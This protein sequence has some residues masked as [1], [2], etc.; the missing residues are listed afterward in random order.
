MGS[1]VRRRIKT[2]LVSPRMNTEKITVQAH[3]KAPLTTCW[4]YWTEPAHI[5]QWNFASPDWHCPRAT[6]DLRAGGR[7][8]ARMEARDGSVGFDFDATYDEV[9]DQQRLHYTMD[10]GRRADTTF[11]EANGTTH[12]AVTFDAETQNPIAMQRDGWQ[13][14]LDNF[15]SYTE[16]QHRS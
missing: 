4:S 1:T 8:S 9:A 14:I 11:A 12:V 3:I 5:T 6:N 10:D 16:K 13:A 2:E 15:K 7:Y